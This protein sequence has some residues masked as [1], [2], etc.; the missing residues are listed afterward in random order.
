MEDFINKIV[1]KFNSKG[2]S[3]ALL[4]VMVS[5][6]VYYVF[7]GLDFQDGFYHI[8]RMISNDPYVMAFLSYKLGY[9]WSV[10]FG[11]SIVGFRLFNVVLYLLLFFMPVLLVKEKKKFVLIAFVSSFS[12]ALLNWNLI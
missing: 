4:F 11:K 12:F 7:F 10:C 5:Y 8:N 3:I 6:Q 2:I 1:E 9:Y